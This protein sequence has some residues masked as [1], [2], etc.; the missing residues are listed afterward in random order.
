MDDAADDLTEYG[1]SQGTTKS[2]WRGLVHAL[3][4]EEQMQKF[5]TF[6][7]IDTEALFS[8][9]YIDANSFKV[10][11]KQ[12]L[13]LDVNPNDIHA[14]YCSD[15]G[16]GYG[17]SIELLISDYLFNGLRK[18]KNLEKNAWRSDRSKYRDY[19]SDLIKQN[20]RI[21]DVDYVKSM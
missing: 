19:I 21:N 8:T 2:N 13:I 14:G 6:S 3:E 5:N 18:S 17:K 11:R 15:F 20:M 1:F 12:G 9:S 4:K 7:S 10:F 16:T